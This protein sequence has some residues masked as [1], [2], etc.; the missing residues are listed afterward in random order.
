[1]NIEQDVKNVIRQSLDDTRVALTDVFDQNFEKRAFFN[2]KWQRRKGNHKDNPLLID[3]GNLRRSIKSKTSDSK[4]VFYSEL[5]YAGIHNEGGVITV[6]KKMKGYF[7]Y[8][9]K[10]ATGGFGYTKKG[11]KRNDKRNQQLTTKAE[12]Y[13]AMALKKVGSKII[14]PRRQFIGKHPEVEKIVRQI[15]ETNLSAFFNSNDFNI[16]SR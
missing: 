16:T 8:K 3:T 5:P 6:T 4:I 1:M 15:I 14:I 13:K 11:E 12:F 10:E 2:I 7:W 9:Y